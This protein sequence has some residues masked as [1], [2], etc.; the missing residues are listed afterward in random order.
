MSVLLV[1]LED[2]SDSVSRGRLFHYC[3]YKV[4]EV[5]RT[6]VC[7]CGVCWLGVFQECCSR[8]KCCPVSGNHHNDYDPSCCGAS[9]Q[10]H[11][12]CVCVWGCG[13]VW[14]QLS[15]HKLSITFPFSSY[16]VSEHDHQS[17]CGTRLCCVIASISDTFYST[18]CYMTVFCFN[19]HSTFPVIICECL[20][21][22]PKI[23]KIVKNSHIW[24]VLPNVSTATPYKI[25][26]NITQ[27][28]CWRLWTR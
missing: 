21:F 8:L 24:I 11:Q 10:Q 19:T 17:A 16:I 18:Y 6:L 20:P 1:R 15:H 26:N 13:C 25:Y 9:S 12:M 28:I 4:W 23:V 14:S 3:C 7:L 22:C 5:Q 27:H 2:F